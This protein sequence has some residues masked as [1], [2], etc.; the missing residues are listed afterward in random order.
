MFGEFKRVFESLK[1][2]SCSWSENSQ[3]KMEAKA[4][5]LA[6]CLGSFFDFILISLQLC[7]KVR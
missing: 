4:S 3:Q 1:Q 5:L 7:F 2:G 6:L